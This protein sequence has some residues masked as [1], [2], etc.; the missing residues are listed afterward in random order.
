MKS[1]SPRP[2]ALALR[3]LVRDWRAGE[4]RILVAALLI[5]VAV[6]SAI[7]FFTNR[8]QR[9][10]VTQSAELLGADLVL[11]SPF[12]AAPAWHARART[13]GLQE[14][15]GLEFPSVVLHGENMTLCTIRAVRPGYP[16]R[17]ALRTTAQPYGPERVT[18]AIPAAGEAWVE[19][20]L[21]PLLG[22]R[23][24]GDLTLGKVRLRI[25]RVLAYE[26]GGAGNLSAVAPTVLVNR[27]DVAR[28][29]LLAPGSRVTHVY[30]FAGAAHAL[31][32]YKRWLVPQLDSSQRLLDVHEGRPAVGDALDRAERYLG[33]AGLMAVLLA[34]VA[35]AM[36][37]RR[38]SE[39]HYD[40][41]A[42]LRCL[43]ASQRDIVRLYLLQLLMIGVCGSVLG[44]ALGYVAHLGLFAL[45]RE[46]LPSRLPPPGPVP[47]LLGLLTGLLVLAGFGL[48]PVLRLRNVPALRVLR[49]ELAPL[50][51]RAWLVYGAAGAAMTALLWRYTGNVTLT[52][53]VLGGA[54]LSL[55]VFGVLVWALLRASRVLARGVGVAWRHGLNN[56]WRRP[57]L[58]VG[59]ILTFGLVLLAMATIGLLR[60]DLL[61]SWRAQLPE[62]AP[63]YF[64]VNILPDQ[65]GAFRAFL[66]RHGVARARLYPMVRGR[67]AE[68]NGVSV[69]ERARRH[70]EENLRRPLNLS[71]SETLPPGN[72]ILA[73]R[74]RQANG[75]GPPQVSVE[76]GIA[77]RLGIRLGDELTFDFA[78]GQVLKARVAS[79]RSVQWDNF[80]PNFFMLFAPGTLDRFPPTYI[81]SF[82]LPAGDRLLLA[83]MVRD[84]PAVTVIDLDR[85]MSQVR[86]ILAQVTMAV[87]YLLVLVLI[88]GFIV[89]FAALQATLEE[90]LFEGALLRTLGASR[91]QLRAGQLAEFGLLGFLAG[92]FAACGTEFITWLLYARVFHLDY[93]L[94]WQLWL[95]LPPLGALLVGLAGLWGTRRVVRSSPLV[96]LR[97][98]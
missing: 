73:G 30:Q 29:G 81:T 68:V 82:H 76:Q 9:A 21:L 49:R 67:L 80:K 5:A 97:G 35:I 65:V 84:F 23:V 17:G 26:P 6:T 90:R 50:P 46:L 51:A 45:L 94:T 66:S 7:G 41:S 8:L 13:L 96:V 55:L 62:Q 47:A 53:I 33:L 32:R 78:G 15:T 93:H 60:T 19:A 39:R 64:V 86:H 74:W 12:P 4:L 63:N 52:L 16:L 61:H 95:L 71:W 25:A 24:G 98:I 75:S 20:R 2:G 38:Y 43:G 18:H 77:K 28:A 44:V 40:T 57:W 48:P 42:M 79:L 89:L 87:E 14:N 70:G 3:L 22:A 54:L 92:L 59:Q 69:D 85:I 10:M 91:Y 34:G 72:R 36:G 31:A 58:A 37:A 56:V 88:A 83:R 27:A 11:H 1:G